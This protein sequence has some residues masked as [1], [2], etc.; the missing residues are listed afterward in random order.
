[1][2]GNPIQTMIGKLQGQ[3]TPQ[4]IGPFA[5][6][7]RRVEPEL[8]FAVFHLYRTTLPRQPRVLAHARREREHSSQDLGAVD[9]RS[10]RCLTIIS[11]LVG[12]VCGAL[13]VGR[14]ARGS[15][16]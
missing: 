2:P 12:T 1:M 15:T 6:F 14:V 4:E 9:D 10:Y 13:L 11:F 5:F 3:V 16:R 8:D 7:R